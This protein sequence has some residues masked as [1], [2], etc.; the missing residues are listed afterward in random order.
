MRARIAVWDPLPAFRRGVMAILSDI[1]PCVEGP[2]EVDDIVEWSAGREQ[3][4]AL[5]TVDSPNEGQ[6]WSAITRLKALQT[7]PIVLAILADVALESY[8]RAI[9]IGVTSAIARDAPPEVLRQVV[10]EALQD[11]SSLPTSIVAALV[12][13]LGS[14]QPHRLPDEHLEWLRALSRGT[15][16]AE[17]ASTMGYSERA[18]YRLL[19]DLYRA[20]EVRNRTEAIIR[21]S[22]SGW[23]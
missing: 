1:G 13:Q 9:S 4:V 6:G 21:A 7:R 22:K 19:K 14:V 15:S 17:L 20:M 18:M 3:H 23:L 10:L 5:V 8:I 12:S 2:E 11:R 16:V